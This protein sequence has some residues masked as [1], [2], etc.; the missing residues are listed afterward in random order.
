M[1]KGVHNLEF[2][3]VRGWERLPDGWSFIG[4]FIVPHGLWVDSEGSRY[5]N[6]VTQTSG[7]GRHHCPEDPLNARCFQKFILS[8]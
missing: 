4:N 1:V 2:D 8:G 5:V 3:A 7:G 6:E